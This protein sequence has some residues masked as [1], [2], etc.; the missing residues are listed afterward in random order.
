MKKTISELYNQAFECHRH[1]IRSP[2]PYNT[3]EWARLSH[4]YIWIALA[5]VALDAGVTPPPLK[6]LEE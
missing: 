5:S 4:R 3:N 2:D 1:A 6:K